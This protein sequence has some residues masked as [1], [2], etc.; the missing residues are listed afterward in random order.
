MKERWNMKYFDLLY[1]DGWKM[2]ENLLHNESVKGCQCFLVANA[3]W[4]NDYKRWIMEWSWFLY[5]LLCDSM[6]DI[7]YDEWKDG[8]WIRW[9]MI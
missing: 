1:D 8:R 5:D 4:Y 9:W 2:N 3:F 7:S 6:H